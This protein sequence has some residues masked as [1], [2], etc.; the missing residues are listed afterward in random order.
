[1]IVVSGFLVISQGLNHV[2]SVSLPLPIDEMRHCFHQRFFPQFSMVVLQ[3]FLTLLS[4]N[5]SFIRRF[6][7][8]LSTYCFERFWWQ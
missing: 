5:L 6:S 7:F 4:D 8:A 2:N 3:Y 1:M